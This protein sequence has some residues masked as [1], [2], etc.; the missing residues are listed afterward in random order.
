MEKQMRILLGALTLSICLLG[1]VTIQAGAQKASALP[2]SA[3]IPPFGTLNVGGL[4]IYTVAQI[5]KLLA[6]DD[7]RLWSSVAQLH[8]TLFHSGCVY[9]GHSG[10]KGCGS[11]ETGRDAFD[12]DRRIYA[13]FVDKLHK[14]G[15]RVSVYDGG[16]LMYGVREE[17]AQTTLPIHAAAKEWFFDFYDHR[18]E[19]YADYL[20]PKPPDPISWMQLDANLKPANLDQAGKQYGYYASM[21]DPDFRR[22]IKGVAKMQAEL[23]VDAIM[24]DGTGTRFMASDR[25]SY[26]L[27][28]LREY[29]KATTTEEERRNVYG[30]ADLDTF[31]PPTA[32]TPGNRPVWIKC[33][34]FR[35]YAQP[36]FLRDIREYIQREV[37]PDFAVYFNY[38]MSYKDPA[39]MFQMTGTNLE[40]SSKVADLILQEHG[41][42]PVMIDTATYGRKQFYE[43]RKPRKYSGTYQQKYWVEASH[44]KPISNLQGLS[45][46][47]EARPLLRKLMIANNTAN[48]VSMYTH[49]P[50]DEAAPSYWDFLRAHEG[51]LLGSQYYSN[52]GLVASSKQAYGGLVTFPFPLSRILTD[53]Q[54]FHRMIIDESLTYEGL[55]GYGVVILPQVPMLSDAEVADIVRY[56]QE[57]GGAIVCG[58]TGEYDGYGRQRSGS[59]LGSLWGNE[60]D[61]PAEV[62]KTRHGE[63]RVAY[64]PCREN[65]GRELLWFKLGV[66]EDILNGPLGELPRLVEWASGGKLS[67]YLELRGTNKGTAMEFADTHTTAPNTVEY[68]VMRQDAENRLVVHL[69]NFG[70]VTSIP[71][72]F[73]GGASPEDKWE[74]NETALSGLR[75]K[76]LLSDGLYPGKVELIS[77]DFAETHDLGF[78]TSGDETTG[79][80]ASF[81]VPELRV[82]D[83]V[84]ISP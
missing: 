74:M 83:I 8:P 68:S 57:G 64:I 26:A 70:V 41:V 31:V 66:P 33:Q 55:S 53:N 3:K 43:T 44:G 18:W 51:Y 34:E 50:C 80:Y 42:S 67:S 4:T 16:T 12:R 24:Y 17:T 38:C 25:N 36:D 76:L 40:L 27:A 11:H 5:E 10:D 23:G 52:V 13:A 28:A 61:F 9:W 81:V 49:Y 22:Y 54:I 72:N 48:G 30:I 59:S 1:S 2:G 46:S 58:R 20:G 75:V 84:V 7:E 78:E 69:V 63:G 29:I 15:I 71:A 45:G 82:Y 21:A 62:L 47:S 19:L 39:G 35:A 60:K 14:M 56:V 32:L 37:N 77:P 65:P 79:R 6:S 73:G